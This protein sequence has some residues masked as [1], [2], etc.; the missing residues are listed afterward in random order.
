M[1]ETSTEIPFTIQMSVIAGA[2]D[3]LI[4]KKFYSPH[5]GATTPTIPS[6]AA[7]NLSP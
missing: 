4:G 3:R 1:S 7:A 6:A 2:A 5:H